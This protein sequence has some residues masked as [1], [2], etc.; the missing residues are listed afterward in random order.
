MSAAMNARTVP[1][2]RRMRSPKM[3]SGSRIGR[4]VMTATITAAT[5]IV[6]ASAT[7]AM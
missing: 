3:P 4:S 7:G 2:M 6:R 5:A 1:S